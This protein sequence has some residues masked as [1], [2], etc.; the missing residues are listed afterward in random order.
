MEFGIYL[1]FGARDLINPEGMKENSPARKCREKETASSISSTGGTAEG[2]NYCNVR[3][4]SS[5][6]TL[7]P[8]KSEPMISKFVKYSY[9]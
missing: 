1:D 9:F 4:A 8:E 5:L 7:L 2:R 3:V 6:G